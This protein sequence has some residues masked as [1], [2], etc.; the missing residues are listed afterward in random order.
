MLKLPFQDSDPAKRD[1]Q[2]LEDLATAYWYSE[3]L[4]AALE[5]RLFEIIER[6]GSSLEDLAKAAGCAEPE[7]SRLLRV[8]ERLDLVGRVDGAWFNNQLAR[9]FL[10]PEGERYLGDFLIYRRFMRG[11]WR[12]LSKKVFLGQVEDIPPPSPED[13]YQRRTLRYTQ[14]LDALAREKARE[15]VEIMAGE[16]WEP[17]ILDIG[18][19]AGAL[20]KAFLET[21]PT[22]DAYLLDLS[23]VIQAARDLYP[24]PGYWE[25]LQTIEGDFRD[26]T[27]TGDRRYGLII[28][29]NFLHAYSGPEARALLQKAVSLLREDGVLLIHDY[30]AERRGAS[31][32]KGPLYDLN[33]MLNTYN[34]ECHEAGQVSGWLREIGMERVRVRDLATDS[35]VIVAGRDASGVFVDPH[36]WEYIAYELGFRKAYPIA[37]KKVMTV[38]WAQMKCRYG[39]PH[40]GKNLHC[41]PHGLNHYATRVLLDSYERAF[42]VE[43]EPPGKQFHERLLALERRAFLAGFHKAFVLGAGPCA[44][45]PPCPENGVCRA[46]ERARPSMEGSGIDVYGAV[47]TVGADLRPLIEKDHYVKYFGL[48]LLE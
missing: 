8:L 14:A 5:L 41:P 6:A 17:P 13:E 12:G 47:Q 2:Y 22:G 15:I 10:L 21:A 42:L 30:F 23:E 24:Q 44:I 36:Q 39:C 7:L 19:G 29:S 38:P 35:S 4:F 45:C 43:G 20:A 40:F 9:R 34:G 48:L 25:R 28:M 26:I 32:H 33:M 16:T 27:L 11:G 3:V 37:P 18:G 1:F 31:P 46:P